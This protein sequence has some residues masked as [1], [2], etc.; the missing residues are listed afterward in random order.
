[1]NTNT[2]FQSH[3]PV[4][5]RLIGVALSVALLGACNATPSGR[6]AK[7]MKK[8]AAAW[9]EKDYR[10]AA[11]EFKIASQNMPGDAEPMYQLGMSYVKL[12]AMRDALIA[13]DKASKLNPSHE[14]TRYQLSLYKVATANP[15]FVEEGLTVLAAYVAGH[16]S[17]SSARGALALADA[18]LGNTAEAIAG[19]QATMEKDPSDLHPAQ[20]ILA[21]YMAKGDT[22]TVKQLARALTDHLPNSPEA[23]TVRAEVSLAMK[24][25]ADADA[26][27][28]RALE[29]RKDYKLALELRLDREIAANN[30]E[31]ANR[32]AQ[33][34]SN[35]PDK[36]AWA[37]YGNLL[38]LEKR[39]DEGS[40]EFE[41]ILKVHNQDAKL[42]NMYSALLSTNGR[43]KEAA[44]VL[45]GTL[46]K[47]PKDTAALLQ[48][49]SLALDMGRLDDA[50]RD[51]KTM[52]ELRATSARLS[53]Q[54]A[55]LFGA[56]GDISRRVGLLEDAL[57]HDAGFL[58]ARIE[59]GGAMLDAGNAR[60]AMDL[61]EQA[62]EMER[63]SLEFA[64][65]YN[66]ALIGN[67]EFAA[68]RKG[69]DAALAQ[70]RSPGFLFQDAM[71]RAKTQ[72]VA[73][74]RKSLDEAFAQMPS[75]PQVV[76]LLG[77]V[78]K[79]QGEF[80]KF[81]AMVKAAAAK[82]S[83][84]AFLQS[85][86]AQLLARE[87]NMAGAKAAFEAARNA[88]DVADSELE[89]ARLDAQTGAVEQAKKRLSELAKA[90][91]SAKVQIALADLE[92]KTGAGPEA[93]G[94]RYMRAI[95]LDPVNAIAMNNLADLLAFR[96]NKLDDGLFWA[97][98]ALALQPASPAV[99]DTVGW[100]YYRQGKYEE[101]VPFLERSLAGRD[102][103]EAH[104][105]MAA[106]LVAT[107]DRVRGRQE[108]EIGLKQDPNTV[109]K[110]FVAPLFASK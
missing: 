96:Q 88:G 71:L 58:P 106:A 29:L 32:T 105:H 65:V 63:K 103:A 25:P 41:R 110:A 69:V 51:V 34:L 108:Y 60:G 61:L 39:I 44:V 79:R 97:Q 37:S 83:G 107:G 14:G 81:V 89:L 10:R 49:I 42:R 19:L 13:F 7:H 26:Q 4:N 82:D 27:I 20:S 102:R 95:A 38:F 36:E 24:D 40:A 43:R 75:Q 78:M 54:E 47:N 104:Y 53:Y 91:D 5:R 72:D 86:V 33:A 45:E 16:P 80:P 55:R 90:H 35:L 100:I 15:A 17:D 73:G 50:A 74:A 66:T 94:K 8:G 93:L 30:V 109:A 57:K 87:G 1:M 64:S 99:A 46:A 56:R 62:N 21:V 12:G 31:L 18:K 9:A 76:G 52:H 11:L 92:S 77:E 3:M 23:A 101:A 68:A 84:S 59:L 2:T 70:V 6:E 85:T 22:A 48:R 67:G 98:K 28:A